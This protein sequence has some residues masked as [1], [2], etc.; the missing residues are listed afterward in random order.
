MKRPPG[1]SWSGTRRTRCEPTSRA[2]LPRPG[3][4]DR[5][6]AS[7]EGLLVKSCYSLFGLRTFDVLD[8]SKTTGASGLAVD[9]DNDLGG[10]SNSREMRSEICLCR[11]VGHIADEQTY[12]HFTRVLS[13]LD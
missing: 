6:G 13:S 8:E 7:H 9:R 5:E 10:F 4:A 2:F 3:L 11:P 12:C 1:R